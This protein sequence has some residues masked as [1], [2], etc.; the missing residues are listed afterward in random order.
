[1]QSLLSLFTDFILGSDV[2]SLMS[3][4]SV[5]PLCTQPLYVASSYP[6]YSAADSLFS[7]HLP[8]LIQLF[9]A[10]NIDEAGSTYI[11]F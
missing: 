3:L 10:N 7:L 2:I 6:L 8:H 9:E 4:Y 1:M 5:Q 11:V